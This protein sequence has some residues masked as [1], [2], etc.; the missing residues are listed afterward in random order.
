MDNQ[1]VIRCT[2]CDKIYFDIGEDICP[3]CKNK[4]P[5][6]RMDIFKD[7]FGDDNPFNGIGVT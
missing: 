1:P 7:I 5:N 4:P 2:I 3:H 6:G